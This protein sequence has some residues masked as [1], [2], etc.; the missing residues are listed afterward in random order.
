MATDRPGDVVERNNR[1][2]RWFHAGIA[3]VVIVLLGTGWWLWAG[4]EGRPSVVAR[5]TGVAD[6][7]LHTWAGWVLAAGAV[8]GAVAGWRAL[9]TIAVDSVRFRRSDLRWLA[10]WPRAAATGRFE[11]HDGHFDPGQRIANIALLGL[12]GVLTIS[13]AGLAVL[14]GGPLF[15]AFSLIHTWSTYALTPLLVGHVVVASGV[16]PGY[17]GVWRAMHLGGRLRVADA[18]R[19][20]PAW[21]ERKEEDRLGSA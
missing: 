4:Q 2:T 5:A 6:S 8:L 9:R 10:R 3:V 1:R 17:R 11:H 19:V 15:A 21:A 12:L 14:R 16:L 20:W 18:R 13:G 7:D